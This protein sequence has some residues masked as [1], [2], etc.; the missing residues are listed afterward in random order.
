[1]SALRDARD[2][3]FAALQV[4]N[5]RLYFMGQLI[6]V[7]GTW[8]QTVAQGWL[9]LKITNNSPIALGAAVALPWLPMLLFGSYGGLIVD[10]SNKRHILYATQIASGLLALVL[11]VLVTTH[12]DSVGAIFLLALLLG[13]V[14]LFDNPARQSFVQEMVGRELITNAV[15]LNSSL[16]NSGRAI[17]PAVAG[18]LIWSVGIATCFYVN[19]ATYVAVV[20]ALALMRTKDLTPLRTVRRGKKQVRLGWQYVAG[21]PLLRDVILSTAIIGTFAFNFTVTLP[22]LTKVTFGLPSASSYTLLMSS[23]GCGAILGGLFVAHRSRPTLKLLAVLATLFGLFLTVVA[24]SPNEVVATIFMVP[25]GVTSIAFLSTANSLLQLNSDEHMRGRVMSL[26]ATAILGT[27]PI[28]ALAIG[29]AIRLSDPRVGLLIGSLL[30]LGT[31]L[32]LLA[33]FRRDTPVASVALGP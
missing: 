3:T 14:N 10:R 16:M 20:I 9:I 12:N 24:I 28:G 22:Q 15:S 2:R 11:G 21:V 18:V 31:G 4:R 33:S 19:A 13:V 6:S 25:T 8:M 17:G 26:Y 5:F 1:M 30:T 23:M 7:S 29:L 32:W 27:T